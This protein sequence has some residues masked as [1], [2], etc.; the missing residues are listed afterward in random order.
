MIQTL[1]IEIIRGAGSLPT[2]QDTLLYGPGLEMWYAMHN[3]GA[4]YCETCLNYSLQLDKRTFSTS[5]V[6]DYFADRFREWLVSDNDE[7][8]EFAERSVPRWMRNR[9]VLAF[10]IRQFIVGPAI[11]TAQKTIVTND[12]KR[13]LKLHGE[14]QAA[15]RTATRSVS[16]C[17]CG[18][19]PST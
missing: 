16:T 2:S 15:I 8:R 18:S 12:T 10:G 9:R 7:F 5:E 1:P 11:R 4:P 13:K 6:T 17:G 19:K 3:R 14:R